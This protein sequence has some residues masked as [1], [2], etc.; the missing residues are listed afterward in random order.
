MPASK[1]FGSDRPLLW[2]VGPWN[3]LGFAVPN[4]SAQV[5]TLNLPVWRLA[6]DVGRAQLSIMTHIDAQRM[7]YPSPNTIKRLAKVLNRIKVVLSGRQKRPLDDR[8]ED[9]HASSDL[10]PWNLHPVPFFRS[11]ILKNSWLGEYNRLCTIAMTNMYQHSDNNLPLTITVEFAQDI[12]AYFAEIQLLLGTELLGLPPEVVKA[13]GFT[14]D[15]SAMS[16]YATIA[17]RTL[18]YEA[19]NTPGPI[20]SRFDELDL[21]PFFLGVPVNEALTLVAEYPVGPGDTTRQGAR[22]GKL[23][24]ARGA[25]GELVGQPGGHIGEPQT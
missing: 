10:K 14:F 16:G 2:N 25:G 17:S 22:V 7:Q 19:M 5:G 13:D 11:G 21:S 3:E 23:A 24:R 18:S 8:L 15:E 12:W 9:K 6:D 1:R 20:G 4:W